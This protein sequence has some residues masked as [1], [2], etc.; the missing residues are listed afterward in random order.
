MT[1][2][3]HDAFERLR[4][5]SGRADREGSGRLPRAD[6]LGLVKGVW[7]HKSADR[8]NIVAMAVTEACYAATVASTPT[9]EAV[10]FDPAASQMD[11]YPVPY[12][13]GVGGGGSSPTCGFPA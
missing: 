4:E 6:F 9:G 13:V 11:D 7:P 8:L 2:D 3:I 10:D 1:P 12:K 5:A